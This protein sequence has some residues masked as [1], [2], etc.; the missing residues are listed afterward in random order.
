LG[1][2]YDRDLIIQCPEIIDAADSE[3]SKRAEVDDTAYPFSHIHPVN[4][5]KAQ[6]G[7]QYPGGVVTYPSSLNLR[8]ASRAMDGIK[9]RS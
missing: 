3:Y 1:T 4:S 6:K 5:Q 9:K 8:A 2:I 7:K